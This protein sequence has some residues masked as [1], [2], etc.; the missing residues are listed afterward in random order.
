LGGTPLNGVNV[1]HSIAKLYKHKD[2]LNLEAANPQILEIAKAAKSKKAT[3][4]CFFSQPVRRKDATNRF[5][6]IINNH[7]SDKG[8]MLTE[9][10]AWKKLYLQPTSIAN[11]HRI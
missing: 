3:F 5:Y 10:E 1:P 11:T 8:K 9:L 6:E 4:S 7:C 2:N